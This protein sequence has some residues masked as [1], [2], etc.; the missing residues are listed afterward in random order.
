MVRRAFEA[1]G[2]EWDRGWELVARL[3]PD[4]L[5]AYRRMRAVP[6]GGTALTPAFKA[7][8]ELTVNA[9]ATH[10]NVV[11]IQSSLR[12]AL[13]AKA[14]PR[15]I[16]E[17]LE[18]SATVGIHAMNIGVPLLAEVLEERGRTRPAPLSAEQDRLKERFT[19]ERGYWHEFW[20]D[21]LELDPA[22]FQAYL[23]FS[24]VPWHTGVLTPAEKE[25]VYISFDVAATHLYVPGTK[26]HI[27]NALDHG[28]TV[29]QILEVMEIASL[30]GVQGV[31]ATMQLLS[32][33]LGI[34]DDGTDSGSVTASRSGTKQRRDV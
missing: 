4:F 23:D 5:E 14:D 19:R 25:L 24:T 28:A 11:E 20:N 2:L 32:R 29:A 26:L 21:M 7:L 6:W 30:L 16:L 27:R 8:I 13:D 22:M 12:R 1:D 10:L 15:A 34:G 17:V 9:A 3:D 33:E 31:T 18:L